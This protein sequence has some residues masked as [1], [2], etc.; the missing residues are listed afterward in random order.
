MRERQYRENKEILLSFSQTFDF[1]PVYFFYSD[2]SD[3]IRE[4]NFEGHL[5]DAGLQPVEASVVP[6]IFYSAEFSETENLG[7]KGLILMDQKLMPLE[8]PFPFY[9]RKYIF[10]GLISMSKARMVEQYNS[11]LFDTYKMWF[12]EEATPE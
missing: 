10:G 3:D 12:P 5:F 6:E 1:C 9:Q 7:I 8:A 2:A 4:R 11:R